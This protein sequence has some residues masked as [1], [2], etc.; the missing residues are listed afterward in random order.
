MDN[1]NL[2]DE[3]L[4]KEKYIK[5]KSKYLDL[6]E[7]EG[8]IS[9]FNNSTLVLFN[10]A[11]YPDLEKSLERYKTHLQNEAA[12]H[13]NEPS[14][15]GNK[16]SK[17]DKY[18]YVKLP[19]TQINGVPSMF[20][21]KL[22]SKKIEPIFDLFGK[23]DDK[24]SETKLKILKEQYIK[25]HTI[26]IEGKIIPGLNIPYHKFLQDINCDTFQTK[27]YLLA[28]FLNKEL[29]LMRQDREIIYNQIIQIAK[30]T[31][32]GN[33]EERNKAYKPIAITNKLGLELIEKMDEKIKENIT[34]VTNFSLVDEFILVN[35]FNFRK[36]SLTGLGDPTKIFTTFN[37]NTIREPIPPSENVMAEF[38]KTSNLS[39]STN[40]TT[41][42]SA[43]EASGEVTEGV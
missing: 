3:L 12:L 26:S 11:A 31:I 15:K 14:P 38:R 27:G 35:D 21:Y 30:N 2:N 39:N 28:T 29:N 7:Q 5:Y 4:Y 19:H 1:L 13:T 22:G 41:A 42:P 23:F 20:I 36:G 10:K 24:V 34:V 37:I 6:K 17:T 32:M 16:D 18:D 33:N 25:K 40:T 43:A 8:G 9:L